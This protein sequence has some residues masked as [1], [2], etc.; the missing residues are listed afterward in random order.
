M[1][2]FEGHDRLIELSQPESRL[3][4]KIKQHVRI[5][6]IE[7]HVGIKRVDCSIGVA[8]EGQ[9]TS[10]RLMSL[11]EIGFQ[12]DAAARLGEGSVEL[13]MKIKGNGKGVVA[14]RLRFVHLNRPLR[15]FQTDLERSLGD[16]GPAIDVIVYMGEAYK[17][18]RRRKIRIDRDRTSKQTACF[19]VAAPGIKPRPLAPAQ[20]E[21]VGLLVDCVLPG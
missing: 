5:K 11:C 8:A 17:R 10:D 16:I 18:M 21:V 6:R 19:N 4:Q 9:N 15:D 20:E 14:L 13:P 2:L 7:P 3:S 12:C 1:S